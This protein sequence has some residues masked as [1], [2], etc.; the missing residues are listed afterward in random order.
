MVVLCRR[1][2]P[3]VR[4]RRDEEPDGR[5][6]PGGT[7]DPPDHLP[8]GDVGVDHV[9]RAARTVQELGD[10]RRD[11]PVPARRVV[12]HA[13]GDPGGVVVVGEEGVEMPARDLSAEPAE[14][15]E[16]DELELG[17]DRSRH[18][19]EQ[20]VEAAVVEVIL[21]PGAADPPDSPVDD[22]ELAVVDVAERAEVP[23]LL[24]ARRRRL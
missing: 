6:A 5:A 12:Q 9:Q 22:E 14:R 13:G 8:V 11:R 1:A 3:V 17:H 23:L 19:E 21:D 20:V 7:L 18:P 2:G 16:E 24:A 10:R 15:R 4:V